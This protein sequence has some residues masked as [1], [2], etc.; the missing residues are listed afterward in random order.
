MNSHIQR[1]ERVL[2]VKNVRQMNPRAELE[3]H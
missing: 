1:P 3:R 2:I